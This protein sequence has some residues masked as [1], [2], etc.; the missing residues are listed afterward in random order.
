MRASE[1]FSRRSRRTAPA[2]SRRPGRCGPVL[3]PRPSRES[4]RSRSSMR[5]TRWRT[6]LTHAQAFPKGA[7]SREPPTRQGSNPLT[8]MSGRAPERARVIALSSLHTPAHRA[9]AQASP[10]RGTPPEGGA[11]FAGRP[12]SRPASLTSSTLSSEPRAALGSAQPQS[13]GAHCLS[14]ATGPVTPPSEEAEAAWQRPWAPPAEGLFAGCYGEPSL[15]M[16][17]RGGVHLG[18]AK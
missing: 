5:K 12:C 13:T 8:C 6:V 18:G 11:R 9:F 14:S 10:P 15:P 7:P 4:S 3:S 2:G 17:N 1:T 16:A